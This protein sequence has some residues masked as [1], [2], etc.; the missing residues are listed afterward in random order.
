MC[1]GSVLPSPKSR[2][3]AQLKVFSCQLMS[4]WKVGFVLGRFEKWQLCCCVLFFFPS[5]STHSL[6]FFHLE[7][8]LFKAWAALLC[9]YT[10]PSPMQLHLLWVFVHVIGTR[11]QTQK[12]AAVL[13]N[14]GFVFNPSRCNFI[15]NFL[16]LAWSQHNL[17]PRCKELTSLSN[18]RVE[19]AAYGT[20]MWVTPQSD[21]EQRNSHLFSTNELKKLNYQLCKTI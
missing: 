5:L 9:V 2:F 15:Q 11:A 1:R 19:A 3:V 4:H 16:L 18:W 10:L 21:E 8:N 14:E 12:K 20:T 17:I 6:L 13:L 7:F